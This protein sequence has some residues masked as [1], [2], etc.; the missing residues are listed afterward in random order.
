MLDK[1][2]LDLRRLIGLTCM[3]TGGWLVQP[4]NFRG[5]ESDVLPLAAAFV[6]VDAHIGAVNERASEGV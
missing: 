2:V 6:F 3:L 4:P 1:K 5:C